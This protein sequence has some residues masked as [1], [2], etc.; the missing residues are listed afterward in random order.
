MPGLERFPGEGNDLVIQTF[1][2]GESHGQKSLVDTVHEVAEGRTW[3]STL[4]TL[5][6][7]YMGQKEVLWEETEQR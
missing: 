7:A 3:L 2:P 1:L 6:L 4:H 5:L